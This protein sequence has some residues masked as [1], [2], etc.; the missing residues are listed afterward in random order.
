MAVRSYEEKPSG[1]IW[2]ALAAG[3]TGQIYELGGMRGPLAAVQVEGTNGHTT[4][5]QVSNNGVDFYTLKGLDGSTDVALTADG[6]TEFSTAARYIRPSV[7][8]GSGVVV[9]T[10]NF[11]N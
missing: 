4:T 3:D 5:I 11:H 2:S 6:L 10:L 8:S 9:V 7:A 1:A